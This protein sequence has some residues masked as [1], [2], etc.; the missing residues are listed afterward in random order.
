MRIRT[1]ALAFLAVV[2]AAGAFVST[3]AYAGA[4]TQPVTGSGRIT[5]PMKRTGVDHQVAAAHGYVV[6]T[7]ADGV[8]YAAKPGDVTPFNT[9]PGDCGISWINFV[10]S[11]PY[12]HHTTIQT[13]FQL[14]NGYPGAVHVEW[15]IDIIDDYGVSNPGWVEYPPSVHRWEKFYPFTS[16]GSGIAVTDVI[17]GIAIL[18]DGTIC[19]SYDPSDSTGL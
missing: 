9:V 13:G 3:P 8:E 19:F 5:V 17:L 14:A 4:A 18:W 6:R 7:G 1:M 2:V 11:N 10:G 16:A 15:D 12:T